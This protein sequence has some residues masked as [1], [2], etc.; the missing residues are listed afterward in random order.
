MKK[1]IQSI[2]VG[3]LALG[4]I[5]SLASFFITQNV[6]AAPVGFITTWKTDNPGVSNSDQITIPTLPTETYNYDVDWGDSS[7]STGQTGDATHTYAS[8]GTYTV[9]ITGT[10]PHIY[11]NNGGTTDASKILSVEHWG[12]NHW[13]SMD[14]A[15]AGCVHLVINATDAPDLSGVTS[16]RYMFLNATAIN[17]DLSSWDVSNITDMYGMFQTATSFNQDLSSWNVS[18]VTDMGY[19]FENA[20]SFNQP[21]NWGLKTSHVTNMDSM[22][23]YA[24]AFNQDING[25]DTGNVTSMSQMFM[26]ALAFNQPIGSWNVSLVT[27]MS[28]MFYGAAAFNQDISAWDVSKVTTMQMMFFTDYAFDQNLSNWD[29]SKVNDMGGMFQSAISY[30]NKGQPLAWAS[31]TAAVATMHDMFNGATSF[32]ADINDWDTSH[33][34]NMYYMFH[35]AQ[36]FNKSLTNWDVSHVTDMNNMF[37][38]A[39]AFNQ[40]LS[41]WNL[42]QV[43]S[44]PNMFDHAT[45]FNNG[46]HALNWGKSTG[47][48]QNM[49]GMFNGASSF[50]QD[51]NDWDTSQV[52]NMNSMFYETPFNKPLP[53][54]DV[55][56][57]TNMY[58]MF[59]YD[60]LFDQDLSSWNIS[61][62]ADMSDMLTGTNISTD[63]YDALLISWSHLPVSSGVTFGVGVAQYCTAANQ[64][65][66]L[67]E[68]PYSWTINDGGQKSGCVD[69]VIPVPL[70]SVSHSSTGR[71]QPWGPLATASE[72]KAK[73]YL[74]PRTLKQGMK[75]DDVVILQQFLKVNSIPSK[76]FGPKTKSAL[77]A[78]QK[79]HGLTADGVMGLRSKLILEQEI[80]N[81]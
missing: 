59:A 19:M 78:Y 31:K 81:K 37:S 73:R 70:I 33:V 36:S 55:S 64:R 10:F 58:A 2:R 48:I 42:A 68:V 38:N 15:F 47:A 20:I 26:F 17:Q 60:S 57:V 24:N 18:K 69:P 77:M 80:N 35:N 45:S 11:F 7:T 71:S 40:D 34:I 5:A 41:S 79:S 29:V 63:H 49:S 30:N 4:V 56:Q 52:L 13:S 39:V 75:G 76:Q 65:S 50:N 43:V 8:P 72:K 3:L 32:N 44:T 67:V 25:W 16:T 51:I 61:K 28:H 14:A 74:F 22:F 21:L 12:S 66:I 46:G 53:S 62:V 23:L 27:T 1:I 9:T 54:W 6:Q